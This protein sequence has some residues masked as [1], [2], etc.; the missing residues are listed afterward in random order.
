MED[1]RMLSIQTNMLAWNAG[2]QYKTNTKKKTKNVEKLSSGYKVN[3]AADDAAGLAISEKMRRQIRGLMQGSD[4]IQDGI[5][6]VQVADG[7][8]GEVVDILQRINE[9]S[10]KAYNDTNTQEDREYIQGEVTHLIKEIERIADITTFN[11]IEVLKG[12]PTKTVKIEADQTYIGYFEETVEREVPEWLKS[13]IDDKLEHHDYTGLTQDTSGWMFKATTFDA[14]GN[15]TDGLYYGPVDAGKMYGVYTYGGS[16]TD[17]LNDNPTAKISFSELAKCDDAVTLYGNMLNLLGCAIGVPCGTCD[18]TYYGIGFAGEV[19]GFAAYPGYY[20]NSAGKQVN[21]GARLDVSTWKGFVNNAGENVN[22][23]DKIKELV[24]AHQEDTSLTDSEKKAQAQ[25][26]AE[27]IAKK[28]CAKTYEMI[29][30]VT[31]YKN[32][33]DRA[34]TDGVYDIIVYDYRDDAKLASLNAAD[35][36]VNISAVGTVKIPYSYLVS[37]TEVEM[38]EPLWIVCSAQ[39]PDRIPIDLPL[40]TAEALGITGYDVARYDVKETYSDSY[41]AKLEAWEN[42]FHYET[43]TTPEHTKLTKKYTLI[44]DPPMFDENGERMW[45]WEVSTEEKLIPASSYQKKVQNSSKP[46]PAEGDIIRTV[47]YAP[48][49][50]R[51]IK[52]SLAYVLRCRTVLGAEQNRLEHAYN[53]NQNKYENTTASE[54]IIR[55]TDMADEMV[56]YSNNNILL[57]AG[58]SI[59]SQANQSSQMILQLLQ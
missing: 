45:K 50:N 1:A 56:A 54:S 38:E 17:T 4:N 33:F 42:D 47:V 31:E 39:S 27:E 58:A 44:S 43:V 11:E 18:N 10:V 53:N 37:G 48:D 51:Q 16:W 15:I 55:D 41:R 40:L 13:G 24:K 3:R 35:A 5:S 8:M 23:F 28:L 52:D 20:T 34:L 19:D 49:S 9:L 26:L 30:N 7:A 57:Q 59:L 22:C 29:T 12:N 25:T 36:N 46:I 14:D 6:L 32:H 21:I 2:R